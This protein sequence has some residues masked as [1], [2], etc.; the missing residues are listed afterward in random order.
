[1]VNNVVNFYYGFAQIQDEGYQD[2]QSLDLA[3]T[4]D[5]DKLDLADKIEGLYATVPRIESF[6]L[7]SH[8]EKSSGILLIGTDPIKENELT[9]ISER[10]NEG[11]Y[12]GPN[13]KAVL[14]AS[15]LKEVLNIELG[16]T[17]VLISQGYHGSNAAGKYVIKGFV[18]FGS[19][20]LNKSMIFMPLK[21]AQWFYNTEDKITTATL[22]IKDEAEVNQVV[23][24]VNAL[25]P[26]NGFRVLDW[27]ELIP[28]LLQAKAL[29]EAGGLVV[30]LILYLIISFGIFGTILMMAREREYEFGV[31]ISIGMR[32][33]KLALLVW[34]EMLMIALIG[35]IAGILISIPIVAYFQYNPIR[36]TGD[37][38][39]AY[40]K[41][42][43]E[44]ILP[45]EL[46]LQVLVVQALLVF[47]I[48]SILALYPHL[49]I[50]TLKPVQALRA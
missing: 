36:F 16:D 32:R 35:A 42:G 18:R 24:S 38:A 13:D 2:D 1:M 34:L 17:L 45:A 49:K 26:E 33:G 47:I 28:E 25:L 23:S 41:F 48:T 15:G 44:P 19:P 37:Y 29:D 9:G 31:L 27:K 4:W 12:I 21:E 11:I 46:N 14:P 20:E 30:I 50:K 8:K 43:V 7:A 40:E 5:P 3:F 6:A 39:K 22:H 10:V